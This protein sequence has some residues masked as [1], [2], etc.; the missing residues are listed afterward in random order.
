[1]SKTDFANYADDNIAY[2]SVDSIDDVNKS[3]EDDSINFFK[4]FLDIQLNANSKRCHLITN[5][6]SCINLKRRKKIESST[7]EKLQWNNS[8][9]TQ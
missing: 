8:I 3:I 1:M 9:I 6:K 5:K 4:W 7:C 2:V